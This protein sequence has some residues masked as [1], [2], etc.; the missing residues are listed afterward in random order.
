MQIERRGSSLDAI[1]N[2]EDSIRQFI[3]KL[4][5]SEQLRA[6]YEA[7]ATG[8]LLYWQLTQLG[9]GCVVV[10]PSLVQ[11]KPGDRVKTDR[12]DALKLARG[13]RNGDLPPAPPLV[14]NA[15]VSRPIGKLAEA[16]Q[17][18]PD[19]RNRLVVPNVSYIVTC[20]LRREEL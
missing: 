17:G 2:R 8:F 19:Q 10:A 14:S 15:D 20:A 4:G 16:Y 5:S 11:R 3:K 9:V 7:G 6:C 18:N 12:R 13:H 1:A